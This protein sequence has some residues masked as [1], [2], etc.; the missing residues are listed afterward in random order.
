[1]PYKM[2]N[3]KEFEKKIDEY[4]IEY[5]VENSK[6]RKLIEDFS[7]NEVSDLYKLF[8]DLKGKELDEDLFKKLRNIIKEN[9]LLDDKDLLGEDDY[10]IKEENIKKL[11]N[12]IKEK[13]LEYMRMEKDKV[14][15]TELSRLTVI[16]NK[17]FPEIL[18]QFIN[19]PTETTVESDKKIM[20]DSILKTLNKWQEHTTKEA[21]EEDRDIIGAIYISARKLYPEMTIYVPGRIKSARSSI[22]NIKKEANKSM[23]SIVPSDLERGISKE[24]ISNQFSMKKANT[25]FTGFT[26][27]LDNV[28]ETMHFDKNAPM[29][30]EILKLRKIQDDCITFS[31]EIENFLVEKED[32]ELS[33]QDLMQIKLELLMRLRLLTYEECKKEY[34]GTSFTK[35]F[36]SNKE[37]YEK[38][39]LDDNEVLNDVEYEDE[40]DEIYELIDELKKRVHDKYQAK[41]LE[42]IV[43][44]IMNEELLTQNLQVKTRF[45]KSVKKENGFCADY[46]EMKTLDG[47]I[48]ELQALT[49]MRFRESK[50]GS[51][52]HSKLP[53]KGIDIRWFF[54]PALEDYSEH[55]YEKM[56]NL[57][58]E[59]PIAK[60]NTLYI[61]SDTQLS[62]S[63]KRLKRR[64]KAAEQSIRLKEKFK[65]ENIMIDGKEKEFSLAQYLTH[66]SEFVSPKMMSSS[67]HH[68]RFHKGV[69]GYSQKTIVSSFREVL[70]KHDST[71]CLAQILIDRLSE[72]VPNDKNE[73]TRNG[74]IERS[75]KRYRKSPET[76]DSDER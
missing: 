72:I 29:T 66:F 12:I 63:D 65:D 76:P 24:D 28:D 37:K 15:A 1:M 44:E 60:K 41:I 4:L 75:N 58:I 45:V 14:N 26:I 51:A 36:L 6:E 64:L 17:E 21:E 67:S 34:K 10:E 5:P 74:I 7:S 18:L 43:P 27:V 13:F 32:E 68:T 70:L 35:L 39:A 62:P 57:L 2:K 20:I 53:N 16:V 23:K 47:R 8:L 11:A 73:I 40:L 19:E 50:D 55:E 48:I 9:Y 56:I 49:K 33:K 42:V 59:T 22:S 54:E 69:A 31:H 71:S 61:T 25:D 3:R 46:Y 38:E 30:T 52:D